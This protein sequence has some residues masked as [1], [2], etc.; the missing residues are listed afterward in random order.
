MIVGLTG[1]IGSGKSIVSRIFEVLGCAVFNSDVAAKDVYYDDAVKSKVLVLLGKETYDSSGRINK[2]HISQKI[3]N[4]PLLLHKLNSIIHPAVK[5]KTL[6]FIQNNPG[7]ILVKESALLFEASLDQ[8]VDVIVTVAAPDA[9]RIQRVLDRDKL[10]KEEVMARLANQMPQEEKVA[11]AHH[12]IHNDGQRLL[13]PQ[14]L[15][16]FEKLR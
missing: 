13:I 16:I 15:A 5:E 3:F 12:V 6:E 14:C 9:L 10:S 11:R 8:E 4:D 2:Q 7:R 1:G